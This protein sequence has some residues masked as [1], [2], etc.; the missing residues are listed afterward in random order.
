MKGAVKSDKSNPFLQSYSNSNKQSA[1]GLN[2][3]DF[4]IETGQPRNGFNL[5]IDVETY[6]QLFKIRIG[7]PFET[8]IAIEWPLLS[9]TG[10]FMDRPIEAVH[11]LTGVGNNAEDGGFRSKSDRNRFDY[12]LIRNDQFIFKS[13][14]PF[15]LQFGDPVVDFKW[16]LY[17]ETA[18]LP[19]ISFKVSYK[20]PWDGADK[21]P[22]NLIS[23]GRSDYG[24]YYLFS[25]SFLKNQWIGYW[26]GGETFLDVKGKDFQE[27]LKHTM[28]ALEYHP[29]P[30]QS[31]LV[32]WAHQSSI[33]PSKSPPLEGTIREFVVDRGL[34]QATDLLTLGVRRR[35][36]SFV[37]FLGFSED[38]TQT[39]NE[40]DFL[41]FFGMEWQF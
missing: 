16:N 37:Y 1:S 24:V 39:R 33:F 19:N 29:S 26:E 9:F 8:E 3:S 34:G 20:Y 38:I 11:D 22:R 15:D 6:R 32:Q 27:G 25:K 12:Y 4:V 41:L 35:N 5:Y 7:L 31:W 2:E 30:E 17:Q 13:R 18:K 40:V 21:Y 23:S 28:L 14:K 10:G 36:H